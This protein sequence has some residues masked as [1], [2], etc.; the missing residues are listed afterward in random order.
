MDSKILGPQSAIF[1]LD[2]DLHRSLQLE[3]LQA[4]K[5]WPAVLNEL[6]TAVKEQAPE[7]IQISKVLGILFDAGEQQQ[8]ST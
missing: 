3:V 6:R 4:S 8:D 5:D 7:N 1:K 2:H